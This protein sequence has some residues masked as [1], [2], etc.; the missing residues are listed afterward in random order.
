MSK[1]HVKF[2]SNDGFKQKECN[3]YVFS[4]FPQFII[5]FSHC[6][7]NISAKKNTNKKKQNQNKQAKITPLFYLPSTMSMQTYYVLYLEIVIQDFEM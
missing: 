2:D 4:M 5:I 6:L 3:R 7:K 1:F